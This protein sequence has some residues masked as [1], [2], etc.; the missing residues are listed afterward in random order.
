MLTATPMGLDRN[1]V[2]EIAALARLALSPQEEESLTT[3]LERILSYFSRLSE[4]PTEDVPP[5][6]EA[7]TRSFRSRDDAVTNTPRVEEFL[8]SAP[9]RGG[10]FFVVPKIIE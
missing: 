10:N 1:K 9:Q 7:L 5:A 2:R 3:Q 6:T 8:E 4:V